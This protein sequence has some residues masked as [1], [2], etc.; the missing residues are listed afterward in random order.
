[1]SVR[2]DELMQGFPPAAAGLV[3]RENWTSAPYLRWGFLHTREI[4][5]T[6][7]ISRGTGPVLELP[8]DLVD[9]EPIPFTLPGGTSSTVGEMLGESFTDGFLVLQDGRVR[10]ERYGPGMSPDTTHLLQSVSKSITGT[11]A[12]ILIGDGRLALDGPVTDVIPELAGSSFEGATVRHVL[13]MRTGT[14]YDETYVDR[15]ADVCI[16]EQVAGWRPARQDLGFRNVYEQIASLGNA[17]PHG[18]VFRYRSILTDLLAWMLERASGMRLADL[19][20]AELWSKIG[21]ERDAEITMHEGVPLA[22]GGI[23]VT[24]R[25]LARFAHVHMV[26]GELAGRRIVPEEW[27]LDTRH[28]DA[29]AIDAYNRSP[30]AKEDP[31]WAYRNQWWVIDPSQGITTG[32]GIHGQFAYVNPPAG[33]VCVKLST[34][35]DALDAARQRATL[36]ACAAIA[37]ELSG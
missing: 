17:G 21:A 5:P 18:E 7:R 19:I 22:D 26:G 15:D 29:E 24:L 35:P 23:C 9:L 36:A 12:G 27:V 33:V 37:A 4:V 3:T 14:R 10:F 8:E 6:A 32:L 25:D 13:D 30:D 16:T 28:P 11:V 31:G 1:L 2:T 20:S 34:W